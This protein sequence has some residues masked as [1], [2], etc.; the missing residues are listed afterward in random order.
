MD[1]VAEILNEIWKEEPFKYLQTDNGS[2][3][4]S[5]AIQE[6]CKTHEVTQVFSRP[7]KITEIAL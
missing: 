4:R 3:F 7:G 6:W 2:E 5:S 1:V